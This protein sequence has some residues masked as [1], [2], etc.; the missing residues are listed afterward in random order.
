MIFS[1]YVKYKNIS[2]HRMF[3]N[4]LNARFPLLRDIRCITCPEMHT[5]IIVDLFL[6]PWIV[7]TWL[8]IQKDDIRYLG[9]QRRRKP[10][11]HEWNICNERCDFFAMK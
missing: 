9:S 11:L 1:M 7:Y 2:L 4:P 5:I 3:S 6:S 10:F 8:K